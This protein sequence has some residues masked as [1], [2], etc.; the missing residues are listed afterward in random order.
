[1]QDELG[2]DWSVFLEEALTYVNGEEFQT[3]LEHAW[4]YNLAHS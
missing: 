1:M 2:D 3:A 4:S